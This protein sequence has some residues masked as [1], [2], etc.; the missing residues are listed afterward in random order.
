MTHLGALRRACA[1]KN[2]REDM[3][4][5]LSATAE[6]PEDLAIFLD[7]SGPRL[8]R[9]DSDELLQWVQRK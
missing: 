6:L 7:P 8:M 1:G 5:F 3:V 9:D 4:A 2:L